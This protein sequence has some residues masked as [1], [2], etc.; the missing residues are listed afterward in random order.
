MREKVKWSVLYQCPEWQLSWDRAR[1]SGAE[2]DPER[3]EQ[4][5][6]AG[7]STMHQAEG[8]VLDQTQKIYFQS[9]IIIYYDLN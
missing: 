5:F 6:P 8:S 7:A 4:T 3:D 9:D 2:S 1:R